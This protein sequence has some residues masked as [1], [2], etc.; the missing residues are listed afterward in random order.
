R[1][2]VPRHADLAFE[3]RAC[4]ASA[5]R[6]NCSAADERA[7]EILRIERPQVVEL[8]ADADQ[9]HRQAELVGDR[10]RDTAFRGAVELRQRDTGDADRLAEE[11]GLLEPVLPC[12]RLDDGPGPGA[13][14]WGPA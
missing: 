4:D 10:N 6:P 1:H 2:R 12:R 8:L 9:L 11:A 7:R 5:K 14:A 3:A 13:P